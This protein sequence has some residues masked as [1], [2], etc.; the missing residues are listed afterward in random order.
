MS[1]SKY[2]AKE[3]DKRMKDEVPEMDTIMFIM[4]FIIMIVAFLGLIFV[5]CAYFQYVVYKYAC[6][7]RKN[8]KFKNNDNDA[9]PSVVYRQ[10]ISSECV[11]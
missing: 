9:I 10:P 8:E 2:L 7:L 4:P 11:W 5:I 3:L 1:M 6:Y